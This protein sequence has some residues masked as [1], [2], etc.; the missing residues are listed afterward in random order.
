MDALAHFTIP[1]S[2]LNNGLHEYDFSIDR[3]FFECFPESLVEDGSVAVHFSF[4]KSPDLYVMTFEIEGTVKAICDRCLEAF[5]LPI[6][7]T[8]VLLVKFDEKELEDAEINYILKETP[9]M[10][11]ARYI[12]EFINL[13]VP[14]TKTHDEAGEECD[15]GMLKFL[16]KEDEDAPKESPASGSIWDALR[17]LNNEN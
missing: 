9:K 8:Q 13:A 15:P 16:T 6:E 14:L 11:V 4:D 12:Y 10:N 3:T 17:G 7:D 5:D 2:G 1:V